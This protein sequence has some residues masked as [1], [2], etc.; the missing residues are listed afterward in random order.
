MTTPASTID[1]MRHWQRRREILRKYPKIRRLYGYDPWLAVRV[2]LVVVG[3]LA[4]FHWLKSSSSSSSLLLAVYG[5]CICVP[6]QH[7]LVLSM[8]ETGHRLAFGQAWRKCNA[9][10][11]M[12]ANMPLIVPAATSFR[13]YHHDHH[14]YQVER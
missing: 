3:Q 8:H 11:A 5:Y 9:A 1:S 7:W 14:I 10:L 4:S 12:L 2:L 6:I 13:L